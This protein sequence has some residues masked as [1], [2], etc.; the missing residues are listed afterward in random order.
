MSKS[1]RDY[2]MGSVGKPIGK[3]TWKP[4]KKLGGKLPECPNCGGL[5]CEIEVLME[6]KLLK[7]GVGNAHYLG[8]PAWP[9]ASPA[10]VA[11][12]NKEKKNEL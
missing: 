4:A 11:A 6:N 8:C 9:W 10:M 1:L 7:G 3:P 2:G 5:V 12:V